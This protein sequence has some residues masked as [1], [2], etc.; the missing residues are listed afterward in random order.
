[1]TSCR[2][3]AAALLLLTLASTPAA[4]KP[5]PRWGK[6][7]E[8]RT[9]RTS[10]RQ[11]ECRWL[12]VK[13]AETLATR[14]QGE[15]RRIVGRGGTSVHLDGDLPRDQ[16]RAQIE[17]DRSDRAQYAFCS[18]LRPAFA[19]SNDDGA[20]IVHF[21]DLMNLGGY[22]MASASMYMRL[23]HGREGVPAEKVLHSMGY[24]PRT[25]S[26]QLEGAAVEAMTRF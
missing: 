25:R 22:Q 15:L 11:G 7:L 12:R 17:W 18:R 10:C 1:M 4:A 13:R 24:H 5:E 23:C 8:G 9:I 16:A 20:L 26:D 21:L 3:A 14:P 19:F 6:A 2:F